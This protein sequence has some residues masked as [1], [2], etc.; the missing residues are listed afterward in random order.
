MLAGSCKGQLSTESWGL[1]MG[2]RKTTQ[3]F[4]DEMAQVNPSIRVLGEYTNSKK[5][6]DIKCNRC[7]H[8]WGQCLPT[9]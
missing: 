6:I 7:G 5:P 9:S 8:E 2:Q 3:Q 4:I 1:G